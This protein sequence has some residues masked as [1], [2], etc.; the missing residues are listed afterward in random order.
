[1]VCIPGTIIPALLWIFKFL[2]LDIY[3]LL[4]ASVSYTWR[5]KAVQESNDKAKEAARVQAQMDY[6]Q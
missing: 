6:Q 1:M 4:S 5:R 3:P 2:D